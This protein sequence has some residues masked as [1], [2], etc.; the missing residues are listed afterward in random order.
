MKKAE[1]TDVFLT[2]MEAREFL[3]I[4]RTKLWHL[5]KEKEFPVYRIGPGKTS[6]L[7]Y[8]KSDLIKWLEKDKKK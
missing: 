4:G 7:R 1:Y 6:S 2:S 8:K 5:T 3:K